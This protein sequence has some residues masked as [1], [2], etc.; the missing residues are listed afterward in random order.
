[1]WLGQIRPQTEGLH[2][3]QYCFILCLYWQALGLPDSPEAHGYHQRR[4]PPSLHPS[5]N[6]H[7]ASQAATA[8][9]EGQALWAGLEPPGA[10]AQVLGSSGSWAARKAGL[11]RRIWLKFTVPC[12]FPLCEAGKEPEHPSEFTVP[13]GPALLLVPQAPAPISHRW[14]EH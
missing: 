12:E 10:R 14:H 9:R 7:L 13:P 11:A 2:Q 4:A 8:S 3:I 1:M 6:L 5:D